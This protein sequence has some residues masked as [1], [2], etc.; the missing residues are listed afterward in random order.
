MRTN[1]GEEILFGGGEDLRVTRVSLRS[2]ISATICVYQG[3]TTSLQSSAPDTV[4]DRGRGDTDATGGRRRDSFRALLITLTSLLR[5]KV[6]S[7]W[8]AR[9]RKQDTDSCQCLRCCFQFLGFGGTR[10]PRL[11]FVLSLAATSDEDHTTE[12]ILN[13][14]PRLGVPS[15]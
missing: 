9:A 2:R 11:C 12:N 4:R 1:R 10:I 8:E 3:E 13:Q 5:A 6:A 14:A 7:E 15:P